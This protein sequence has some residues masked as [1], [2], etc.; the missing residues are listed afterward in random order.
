M[1]IVAGSAG[2]ASCSLDQFSSFNA[3]S[4]ENSAQKDGSYEVG[5]NLDAQPW[6]ATE[7]QLCARHTIASI[8]KQADPLGSEAKP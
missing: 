3:S 8:Q 7:L 5:S 6:T 1:T 4:C 2:I